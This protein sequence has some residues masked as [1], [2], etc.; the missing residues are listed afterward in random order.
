VKRRVPLPDIEDSFLKRICAALDLKTTELA[1]LLEMPYSDLYKML[2]PKAQ[3]VDI[4]LDETWWY[5]AERVDEQ[6][7]LLLAVKQELNVALQKER[8][9]RALRHAS[10]RG[11]STRQSPR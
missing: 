2:G 8:A 6:L 3:I 1:D 7:A 9:Q 11:R 4:D 10:V 5:I